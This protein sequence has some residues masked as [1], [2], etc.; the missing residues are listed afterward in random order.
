[1]ELLV[2]ED[3]GV[4]LVVADDRCAGALS[5]EAERVRRENGH[6]FHGLAGFGDESD[7]VVVHAG[8]F[9]GADFALVGDAAVADLA[10]PGRHVD[11][12]GVD[13]DHERDAH[14]DR[15]D[16]LEPA[17]RDDEK[18]SDGDDGQNQPDGA[19]QVQD[20]E[21]SFLFLFGRIAE[22]QR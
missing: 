16:P 9:A 18:G 14:T 19:A 22:C 7:R 11:D 3:D 5:E 8:I 10:F 13:E 6:G 12:G 15:G 17:I 21:D 2:G 4:T 1:M 20:A